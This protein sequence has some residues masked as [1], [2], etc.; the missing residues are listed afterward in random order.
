MYRWRIVGYGQITFFNNDYPLLARQELAA[1]A[2]A[3]QYLPGIP[4]QQ[5]VEKEGIQIAEMN[6]KLMGKMEEPICIC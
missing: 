2:K 3:Y 1:Y 5:Q 4:T 6:T